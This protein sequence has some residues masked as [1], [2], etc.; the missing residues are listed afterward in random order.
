MLHCAKYKQPLFSEQL[1][2][3]EH[4]GVVEAVRINFVELFNT[5]NEENFNLSVDTKNFVQKTFA[6]FRNQD[7]EALENFSHDD[8][9]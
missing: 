6:Y 9:A 7:N 2:A 4:G 5:L 1:L 8:P 3:F